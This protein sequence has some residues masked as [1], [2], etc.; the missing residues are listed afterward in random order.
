MT[1]SYPNTRQHVVHQDIVDM[2]L[3]NQVANHDLGF[4]L[5]LCLLVCFLLP[6]FKPFSANSLR[7]SDDIRVKSLPI[8]AR[9]GRL[10]PL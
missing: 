5:R 7:L 2:I 6:P 3:S 4:L 9:H 1:H 10:G 8:E